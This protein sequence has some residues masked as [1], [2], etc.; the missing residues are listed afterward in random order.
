MSTLTLGRKG[1]DLAASYLQRKGFRILARNFRTRL[2]E[3]DLVC[4]D[5]AT[6]VFVEVKTR[7]SDDYADPADSVTA[8]KRV[9][10]RRLA[11]LYLV[12]RHLEGS[13]ARFDVLGITLGPRPQFEHLVGAF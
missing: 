2:G 3:I 10:L 5:K 12:T 6:V 13:D 8:R 7:L 4:R 1:E 11:E 9:K